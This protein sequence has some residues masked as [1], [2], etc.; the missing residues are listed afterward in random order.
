MTGARPHELYTL[1]RQRLYGLGYEDCNDHNTLRSD[2]ALKAAC[3]ILPDSDDLASQP[4]LTRFENK[5]SS[6]EL[7]KL[8]GHLFSLY[9]KAHP[10]KHKVIIIDMDST[11]DP[12]HG[13]Q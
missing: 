4:T 2:S 8:S 3:D 13:M 10:G 7:I 1:L 9:L 12:T 11:D 6:R 5:I